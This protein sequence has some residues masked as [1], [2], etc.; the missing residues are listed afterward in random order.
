[1]GPID[2]AA[3]SH[4]PSRDKE[5]G[6]GCV[7]VPRPPS[8]QFA[9]MG[10]SDSGQPEGT[11][12]VSLLYQNIFYELMMGAK[13]KLWGKSTAGEYNVIFRRR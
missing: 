2:S 5:E 10:R 13:K 11:R 8:S 9:V 1:M 3:L 7:I 4:A 6:G 12:V